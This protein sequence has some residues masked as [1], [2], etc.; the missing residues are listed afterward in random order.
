MSQEYQLQNQMT[1]TACDAGYHAN[2]AVDSDEAS[3]A[4]AAQDFAAASAADRSAFEELTTTNGDLSTQVANMAVQNQQLQQQ[5]TQLQ[6]H[7]MCMA[8]SPPP[9]AY[10]PTPHYAP[11]GQGGQGRP[12]NPPR[13]RHRQP[14]AQ[15]ALPYGTRPPYGGTPAYPHGQAPAPHRLRTHRPIRQPKA[16]LSTD[17]SLPH[18][19]LANTPRPRHQATNQDRLTSN[20]TTI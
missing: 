2:A 15:P 18:L 10:T 17:S 20:A 14:Q 9:A 16:Y 6:Q 3:L 1:S 19:A 8:T 7:M 11:N 4:S 13:S 12:R 5:M